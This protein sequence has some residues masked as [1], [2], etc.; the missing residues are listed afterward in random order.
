MNGA[1]S[2]RLVIVSGLSGAG[3]TVVLHALEDHGYYCI[4]NLPVSF[5]AGFADLVIASN[6]PLYR[7]VAVGI[8]ARNPAQ[9]LSG[10]T[11]ELGRIRATELLPELVY[12]EA[13]EEVLIKRFS[14]TRRKHPLSTG[15]RGLRDAI[16][17]ERA[18]LEPIA[19]A[20]DLRI[21][22]THSNI[23]QLRDLV[24][25]R[26]AQREPDSMSLQF[27]SFGYKHGV[28][29]DCDFVFDLRCLPNPHWH[30]RLRDHT[31]RHPEVVAFLENAP[32]VA[33]MITDIGD[34]LTRWIPRFE[35][36]NRSYLTVACGCTGG[37]HRSVYV[38]E[39][40]GASFRARGK[41]VLVSHR[42]I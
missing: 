6:L 18:L 27:L 14:E 40:L 12:V 4:D 25:A 17:S 31:G 42:D 1:G 24:R 32:Q 16:A 21:D 38:A 13:D 9:A 19:A 41:T 36:E 30:A 29:P 22:T 20:A 7:Q 26:I 23:H 37:R 8:D 39:Q 33:A 2:K 15:S 5:L 34:F 11:D 28:P 10:F 3:K 35:A